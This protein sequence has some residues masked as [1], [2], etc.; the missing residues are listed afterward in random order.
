MDIVIS[1]MTVDEAIELGKA[2]PDGWRNVVLAAAKSEVAPPAQLPNS[3]SLSIPALAEKWAA[4]KFG[5]VSIVRDAV[6]EFAKWA[7]E[8]QAGG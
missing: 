4:G 2:L 3:A 6:R 5:A 8:Q 1:G 7:Q